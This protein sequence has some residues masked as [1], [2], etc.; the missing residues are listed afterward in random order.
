MRARISSVAFRL[1]FPC[2]SLFFLS[3]SPL[4]V[5]SSSEEEPAQTTMATANW[6]GVDIATFSGAH[7]SVDGNV[8]F[9]AESLNMEFFKPSTHTSRCPYKGTA[10]YYDVVVN[11]ETNK[12]AAWIYKTPNAGM[13]K[14]A[15]HVAFWKGVKVTKV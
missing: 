14:I 2:L 11:G 10:S 15:N 1:L 5:L 8:Y 6:K 13:E 4:R 12:N 9:P 3:L 7:P